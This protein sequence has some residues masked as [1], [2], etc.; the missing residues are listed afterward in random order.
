MEGN[1]CEARVIKKTTSKDIM[2]KVALIAGVVLFAVG[3][4]LTANF[5]LAILALAA[6]IA[7]F[8]IFPRLS[9]E[10]EYVYCDGQLDFDKITNK[11]NRRKH[12][13][14]IDFDNLAV[15]AKEGNHALDGYMRQGVEQLDFS[16]CD[17]EAQKWVIVITKGGIS[18]AYI[19]EPDEAML[20]RMK[21]K[22]MR[23][24]VEY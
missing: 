16:S 15:M 7:A 13:A 24:F 23:K 3:Y 8:I 6:G 5:L 4:L 12:I 1:Y 11:G 14:R 2:I 19:C 9:V 18:K 22:A 20:Q 10:Y 17:P 21:Y